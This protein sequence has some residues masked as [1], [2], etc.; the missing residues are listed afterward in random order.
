MDIKIKTYGIV[1]L[2]KAVLSRLNELGY[3]YDL[4]YL[5]HYENAGY[6]CTI[7]QKIKHG[8]INYFESSD[9]TAV[10]IESLFDE[11]MEGVYKVE[12]S[13]TFKA[14]EG[15]DVE[16]Y[17]KSRKVKFGCTTIEKETVENI[18]RALNAHF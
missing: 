12:T 7:G 16:V 17:P 11:K 6:L 13:I 1:E 8:D 18:V 9:K 5:S 2:N 4:T 15:H 10:S 14:V 3:G